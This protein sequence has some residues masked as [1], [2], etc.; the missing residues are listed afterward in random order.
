[1]RRGCNSSYTVGMTDKTLRELRKLAD[2]QSTYLDRRSTLIAKARTEGHTW[3]ELA[4][5]FGVGQHGLIK[6]DKEWRA[7]LAERDEPVPE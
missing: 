2:G 3:R 4:D 1:M 5:I 6:A 7:R